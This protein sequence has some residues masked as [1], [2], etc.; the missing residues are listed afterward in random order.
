MIKFFIKHIKA[1][2]IISISLLVILLIMPFLTT[3]YLDKNN[4][5]TTKEDVALY[6]IQF[7]QLPP[8]YITKEQSNQLKSDNL[9]IGG[10]DFNNNGEL[11]YFGVDKSV[12]LIE[13]DISTNGN[14]EPKTGKRGIKRLVYTTNTTITRVF[15]TKDHYKTFVEVSFSA[16]QPV[17]TF[18]IFLFVF[19]FYSLITVYSFIY[20][21]KINQEQ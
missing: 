1:T 8:N 16:L 15:Y 12:S 18:F 7:K 2:N 14:Y 3:R 19:Y 5:Y 4:T 11:T 10:D 13:C 9:V 6:I 21:H 20:R 17:R